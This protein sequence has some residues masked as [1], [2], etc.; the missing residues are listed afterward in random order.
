M[1]KKGANGLQEAEANVSLVKKWIKQRNISRDWDRYAYSGRINRSALAAELGISKSVMTQNPRVKALLED[2]D[3]RWFKSERPCREAAYERAEKA[4]LATSATNNQL[5][6]RIATLEA[7]AR[8][9]R[10]QL[11][12][13][14]SLESLVRSGFPGQRA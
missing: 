3:K 4:S 6:R 14:Q 11:E 13:Y 7:E 12:K 10:Q 8:Q 5:I 1:A 2:H 9:L